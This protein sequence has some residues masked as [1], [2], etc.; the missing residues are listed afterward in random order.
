MAG[1][2]AMHQRALT[3]IGD[4]A[5]SGCVRLAKVEAQNRIGDIGDDVFEEC[6]NMVAFNVEAADPACGDAGETDAR[7]EL[8]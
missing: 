2:L 4:R 6:D 7:T 5:F 3:G 1:R 8:L